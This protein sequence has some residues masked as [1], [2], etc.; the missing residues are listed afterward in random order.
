MKYKKPMIYVI[1]ACVADLPQI[2]LWADVGT[3]C[4]SGDVCYKAIVY[5]ARR[6]MA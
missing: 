5:K 2:I 4:M 3:A 1:F 6:Q